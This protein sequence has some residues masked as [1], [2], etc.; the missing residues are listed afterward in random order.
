ME[1][2]IAPRHLRCF[3][4]GEERDALIRMEVV[5]PEAYTQLTLDLISGEGAGLV[6]S[7]EKFLQNFPV[8]LH[9][10]IGRVLQ[11]LP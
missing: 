6:E 9:T 11:V 1:V 10:F 2:S 7:T 5:A 3:G 8:E 4:V